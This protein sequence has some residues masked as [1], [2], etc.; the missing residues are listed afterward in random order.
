MTVAFDLKE[1]FIEKL[2]GV[3]HPAD[4]ST[5]PQMLKK[6]D[7]PDY[8]NLI[9]EFEKISGLPVLLNTSFNLHGDAIVESAEQAIDTFI[10]SDLDALILNDYLIIRSKEMI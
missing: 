1:K 7:N 6:E 9:K 2:P 5:R 8:Y 4:K 10:N 3:I